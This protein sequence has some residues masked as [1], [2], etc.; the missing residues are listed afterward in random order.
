MKPIVILVKFSKLT[1]LNVAG[2]I[3]V[4]WP[5]SANSRPS[6]LWTIAAQGR[7]KDQ[8]FITLMLFL[9]CNDAIFRLSEVLIWPHV[10]SAVP[11]HSFP[12]IS[13]VKGEPSLSSVNGSQRFKSGSK[14]MCMQHSLLFLEI[15]A[16]VTDASSSKESQAFLAI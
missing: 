1:H 2:A 12:S 15:A 7:N 14:S 10:V 8:L 6:S 16:H 11:Q 5:I 3:S 13:A 4:S 9:L